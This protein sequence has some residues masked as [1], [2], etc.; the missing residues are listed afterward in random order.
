MGVTISRAAERTRR[1]ASGAGFAGLPGESRRGREALL[2]TLAGCVVAFAMALTWLTVSRPLADLEARLARGEVI[3][4]NTVSS[5]GQLAPLLTFLP[6]A[7]ESAFVADRIR[8]RLA[9]APAGNVG[10][11]GRLRVSAEDVS[12]RHLPGLAARLA[13]S[14][15]DTV[16][17]LSP[18]ELRQLKP[19]LVVRT[20]S[21]YRVSFLLG[22]VLLLAGFAAAHLIL[23]FRRFQGDEILLPVLLLFCGLGFVLMASLRD[24]LRD[25]PLHS[26]FAQG[27]LAGCGLFVLGALVD[28]ERTVLPRRG[29]WTLA[30]A[31]LLSALLIVFGGGP[32]VSD[33]KVNFLGFQP[34][35]LIKILIALFLAGYFAD[36]WELLREVH[37]R[38]VPLGGAARLLPMP[39]LEYVLPPLIAIG[40]VLFFFFLQKDLGPALVLACLFL[41]LF[42]VARGRSG[43]ALVGAAL[44]ALAFFAGYQLHYPRTVGQRIGMWLAPWDTWF[45][46]GDHLAQAIWSLSAGGATGTG[47]GL[48]EPGLVPEAHTDMVLSALGEQ[49]GFFGLLAVAG[50]YTLL[51]QRGLRAARRSGSA[52]G[53]FLALGFTLLLALET[54]LISGGVLGL[55]PLSG[56]TSPFLSSGR[57]AML[58]NFLVAG[59]LAGVSARRASPDAVRPF[60]GGARWVGVGLGI[61]LALSLWRLADFQIVRADSYLTH[62]AVVLQGDGVRRVQYNPRL[63]AIAATIP[64]GSIVD[65]GGVLLASSDPAEIDGQREQ[66]LKLGAAPADLSGAAPADLSGAAPDRRTRVYPFGGRTFHLL[67]DLRNRVNWTARNTSFAERDARIRLQGYDDYA[68]VIRVRQQDGTEAPQ[69]VVD[70]RDLVPLLRHRYEPDRPEVKQILA[71]DRTVKLTVDVRLELA[72]EEILARNAAQAGFGAAAVVLDAETGDLLAAASYPFPPRLPVDAAPAAS[73]AGAAGGNGGVGGAGGG[74]G[75]GGNGGNGGAGAGTGAGGALVDRAR[76]GIYPPGSTFKV[77][78]ALAALRKDPGLATKTF[79]CKLLPEGRTGNRVRGRLVRDDPTV[80]KPHGTVNLDKGI[81]HSCNAYFAQL[82]T[83]GVGAEALLKTALLFGIPVARPNTARALES[84]LP[85]AA[86]GQGQVIATPLQMARVAATVADQGRMPEVRWIQAEEGARRLQ[87]ATAATAG[88]GTAAAGPAA[89]GPAT[90]SA[91]AA[92]AMPVLDAAETEIIARAMRGVVTE[93]TAAAFLSGV[94]PPMAGKTGTAEVQDKKSH[95]WFIGFAPYGAGGRRLAVAVIVEHGGYGGRLAAP[96]AGEIVRRAAALGLL[97]ESGNGGTAQ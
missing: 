43:M 32:G 55:L 47:M 9:E 61:F 80:T 97:R 38:R 51:V 25:L 39:R 64:R 10:E 11:L 75:S 82:A 50:L 44:V 27:V 17:L 56:V 78:T 37:E 2:L 52:Y 77:V 13:A 5:S 40:V 31:G 3:N 7:Q 85:Q 45:R 93:G 36:R 30:L 48:G 46:G 96:A 54:A 66:L 19:Q 58:A 16:P 20:A 68:G 67:G 87:P 73:G 18:A 29:A 35:E 65:R 22:A 6:S 59:V 26:R 81:R 84:A 60:L 49:L 90:P 14:G 24:P 15:R 88:T 76:Y 92:P 34:V 95:S 33:A 8:Q 91:G 72:A 63:A 89:S 41:I 74:N 4:L 94:Q 79:E 83:Y 57:S 71:R 70:Y 62:G 1:P 69:V 53:F 23:R 21:Q 12:S 42:S 86:Y 28:L